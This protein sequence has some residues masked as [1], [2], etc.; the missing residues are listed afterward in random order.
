MSARPAT[1]PGAGGEPC[2]GG[3]GVRRPEPRLGSGRK[4]EVTVTRL[5]QPVDPGFLYRLVFGHVQR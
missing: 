3:V 4:H 2:I 1:A 5:Q